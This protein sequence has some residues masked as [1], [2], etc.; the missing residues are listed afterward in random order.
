MSKKINYKNLIAFHPGTYVEE[1]V[2]DLN[3]NQAEFAKRLGISA[4]TVSKIINGEERI[5]TATANKLAK[6]TGVSVQTWLN[7]Q[8]KYDA[9][10]AEIKNE[11]DDDE[12]QVSDLIETKYLKKHGFLENKRYTVNEKV[13][14]L[15][16]ILKL[17]NLSQLY[18]F[19]AAVSY[20]RAKTENDSKSIVGANVMLELATN[21]ARNATNTKYDQEKL[22]EILPEI[23][24]MTMEKP[25]KFYP[26]LKDCLLRCGIVLV[27]LPH[28]PGAR[29]N[30]ATKRFKNGSVLLMITDRNKN[31]DNF[32]FS[33]IHELGH[34]YYED[35][36]SD[37]EDEEKY[38][39]KEKRADRFAADFFIPRAEFDNFTATGVFTESTISAFAEQLNISP[40]IVVGRLQSQ[41]II[42]YKNLNYLKTKYFVSFNTDK[43]TT[44]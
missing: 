27:A 3:M 21:E 40:G 8:A 44:A 42:S 14:A 36:Y 31:A 12:K 20:R 23:K 35:F 7:L 33:L 15:R 9:K 2:D 13:Q 28:L 22:K 41:H 30:G 6:I 39:E 24:R 38:H 16:Q 11:K 19:N 1:I 34:I 18:Q 5:S 10:V 4:K 25:E 32:W 43:K 17:S 29:L 26:D 37:Y